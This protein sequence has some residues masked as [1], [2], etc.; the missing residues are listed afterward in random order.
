MDS[1]NLSDYEYDSNTNNLSV[2][3]FSN[4]SVSMEQKLNIL[5]SNDLKFEGFY[6]HNHIQ[7]EEVEED[8]Q[9]INNNN[10]LNFEIP[11]GD[12]NESNYIENKINCTLKKKRGRKR[13]LNSDNNRL[14]H[15]KL[16]KD[17]IKTK[18]QIHYLKFLRNLINQIIKEN[19]KDKN[20]KKFQFYP[21]NYKFTNKV[22]KES[23]ESLKNTRIGEIFKNNVSHKYKKYEILNIKVYNEV[24]KKS[25]VVKNILDKLFYLDYF[26]EY[27]Y[28]KKQTINLSEYGSNKTITLSDNVGFYSDLIKDI[29]QN[30]EK[31]YEKIEKCIQKEFI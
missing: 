29:I 11:N 22:T 9:I 12:N 19:I 10:N 27:Y 25:N 24:T 5:Q 16:A 17:N 26:K 31:Y 14:E 18:I 23:F 4:Q 13:N 8:E 3:S 20:I 21:L 30:D 6:N 1:S 2:I 28:K 7:N 15:N